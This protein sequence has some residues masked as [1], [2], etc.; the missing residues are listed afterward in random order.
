VSGTL[1]ARYRLIINSLTICTELEGLFLDRLHVEG[2][3]L[4]HGLRKLVLQVFKSV[5]PPR[6]IRRATLTAGVT[7][8]NEIICLF[9]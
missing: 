9:V 8:E 2:I 3:G 5:A 7:H 1:N 6:L 4:A